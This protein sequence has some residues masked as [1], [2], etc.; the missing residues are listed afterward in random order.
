MAEESEREIDMEP[1]AEMQPLG[2]NQFGQPT[3]TREASYIPLSVG[4]RPSDFMQS[5]E[6]IGKLQNVINDWKG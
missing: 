4:N 1:H 3:K 5:G 6:M 2:V